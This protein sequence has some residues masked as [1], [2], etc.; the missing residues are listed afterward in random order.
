MNRKVCDVQQEICDT[1]P[2]LRSAGID[3][4]VHER[5]WDNAEELMSQ[6]MARM[7][8]RIQQIKAARKIVRR[9]KR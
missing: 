7:Y 9:I 8:E 1:L 3:Q 2:K 5:Q 4:A 6:S